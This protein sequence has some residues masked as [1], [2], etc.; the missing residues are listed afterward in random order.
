MTY[1]NILHSK[2]LDKYY[3]GSTT[4]TVSERLEKHL[5]EFYSGFHFTHAAND[6]IIFFSIKCQ[7]INQAKGIEA[8]IKR[9]KTKKYIDDLKRYPEIVQRLLEKYS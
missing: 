3:I 7:N 4:E 9:M 2:K 1:C 5:S 6:W 8:H